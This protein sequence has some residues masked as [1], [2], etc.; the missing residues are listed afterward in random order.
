MSG[1]PSGVM[2]TRGSMPPLAASSSARV[3]TMST[4]GACGF[5]RPCRWPYA[6]NAKA[7][8]YRATCAG[9]G[10]AWEGRGIMV[11]W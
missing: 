4:F 2:G 3:W 7:V 9:E 8:W 6:S 1:R 11:P 5:I 10:V